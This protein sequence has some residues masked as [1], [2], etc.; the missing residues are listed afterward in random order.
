M[1]RRDHGTVGCLIYVYAGSFRSS[2]LYVT[3]SY[4]FPVNHFPLFFFL[5]VITKELFEAGT[6]GLGPGKWQP[7]TGSC[8][9]QKLTFLLHISNFPVEVFFFPP[10]VSFR[11]SHKQPASLYLS[12]NYYRP[13][14]V[15]KTRPGRKQEVMSTAA[16][17][18]SMNAALASAVVVPHKIFASCHCNSSGSVSAVW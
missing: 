2:C 15:P 13:F 14:S 9:V 1:T 4:Y 6:L 12:L 16:K 5:Q 18:I 11:E 8:I 7:R 3:T 10:S 17:V